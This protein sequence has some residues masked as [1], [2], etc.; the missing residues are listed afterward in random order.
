[1]FACPQCQQTS[2][3]YR[4]DLLGKLNCDNCGWY[5]GKA[6]ERAPEPEP[7]EV[8][9]P[10]PPPCDPVLWSSAEDAL[11][12]ITCETHGDTVV[13]YG[14]TMLEVNNTYR[15]HCRVQA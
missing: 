5:E 8:T 1:M 13:G 14:P 4:D 12:H 11:L 3:I 15:V 6:I 9:P 7:V 2:G 10:P